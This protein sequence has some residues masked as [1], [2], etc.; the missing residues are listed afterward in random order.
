MNHYSVKIITD[1]CP[2]VKKGNFYTVEKIHPN[3]FVKLLG[4]SNLIPENAIEWA[5]PENNNN[6]NYF[7]QKRQKIIEEHVIISNVPSSTKTDYVLTVKS[8]VVDVK[9]ISEEY[10]EN[11]S[12][13]VMNNQ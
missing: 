3:G 11:V 8:T 12:M 10:V 5:F 4:I 1:T 13:Y 7:V 9:V 6:I 2:F